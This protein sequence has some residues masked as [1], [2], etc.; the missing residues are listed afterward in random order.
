MVTALAILYFF[1]EIWPASP[2]NGR[3]IAPPIGR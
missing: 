2:P 3:V 1:L